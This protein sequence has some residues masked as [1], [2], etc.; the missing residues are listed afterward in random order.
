M[1][2]RVYDPATAQFFSPDPF[3][4]EAGNWQNY[5]RYGYLFNNPLIF[6]DPSGYRKKTFHELE[7]EYLSD[8][9]LVRNTSYR[10]IK[11]A[12]TSGGGGL[13]NSYIDAQNKGYSGSYD[14]FI[15][16][17][18]R[19]QRD[20][21]YNGYISLPTAT[22]A[23]SEIIRISDYHKDYL[24]VWDHKFI[25]IWV[26]NR[27]MD[28]A[29]VG[30]EDNNSLLEYFAVVND[31]GLT[32]SMGYNAI[33]NGLKRKYAYLLSKKIYAKPGQLFQ[34]A[35]S[36]GKS[37]AK[38]LGK[39]ANVIAV[40]SIAYDFGTGNANTA[41]LVDAGM[42]IGGSAA[43]AILGTVAAPFVVGAGIAYGVGCLFGFDDYINE[44][45]D[46]SDD[47]N[48]INKK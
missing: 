46:I 2:G 20:N 1:N 47:I 24:T 48:F 6:T 32:T 30:G 36:I 27:P 19:R 31:V 8:Y 44:T 10:Y 18:E 11:N 29:A 26:A 43:V 37:S 9:T 35:K 21:N 41:T 5:N 39:T 40:G 42:L 17:I 12:G 28:N 4:Q 23:Y 13:F 45:F 3:V 15:A 38:L 34:T 16:T 25:E 22:F 7:M 14:N 33:D